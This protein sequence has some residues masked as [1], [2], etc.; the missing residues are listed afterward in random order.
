[1][2]IFL[3][4]IAVFF[5]N[6]PLHSYGSSDIDTLRTRWQPEYSTQRNAYLE[7]T[8]INLINNNQSKR[9]SSSIA[10]V[11]SMTISQS[12]IHSL[13]GDYR[14]EEVYLSPYSCNKAPISIH[15][16]EE[17]KKID[18]VFSED[19]LIDRIIPNELLNE[20]KSKSDSID[21]MIKEKEKL[22]EDQNKNIKSKDG[23]IEQK[24]ELIR[25]KDE[26][27]KEKDN[28]IKEIISK[29]LAKKVEDTKVK[30]RS[31]SESKDKDHEMF[32][33]K[34]MVKCYENADR[35]CARALSPKKS[36]LQIPN[37]NYIGCQYFKDPSLE[38]AENSKKAIIGDIVSDPTKKASLSDNS[39]LSFISDMIDLQLEKIQ[40]GSLIN[41][42]LSKTQLLVGIV[43]IIYLISLG[44]QISTG[45]S[46]GVLIGIIKIILV[47]TLTTPV[48]T[49]NY[50][51]NES[52]IN[53]NKLAI[54]NKTVI[55]EGLEL[56]RAFSIDLSNSV[57]SNGKE[58]TTKVDAKSVTPKSSKTK[59]DKVYKSV[60][61]TDDIAI[62][63]TDKI[64]CKMRN[65]LGFDFSSSNGIKIGLLIVCVALFVIG[66]FSGLGL[67]MGIGKA[68]LAVC[69]GILADFLVLIIFNKVMLTILAILAPFF[70]CFW[71]IEPLSKYF[72]RYISL[73]ISY[74][75]KPSLAIVFIT[76]MLRIIELKQY[77]S[78]QFE[79][80]EG[81]KY[82][83]KISTDWAF[84]PDKNKA[85]ECQQSFMYKLN[86]PEANKSYSYDDFI[87]DVF[88]LLFIYFVVAGLSAQLMKFTEL[89]DK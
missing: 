74:I 15:D 52:S 31:F 11:P 61:D 77:S 24:D 66:I 84:Y 27:I 86:S 68:P 2:K 50:A 34:I 4:F 18:L 13:W 70:L 75:L 47:I 55:S 44:M 37:Y 73:I 1:M 43:S 89:V 20:I 54:N 69:I 46:D 57:L 28:K 38:F 51:S 41:G 78:C 7:F 39:V 26:L 49:K 65:L 79:K 33:F 42:I 5:A 16:T 12:I 72:D 14:S 22:I 32:K 64:W 48:K 80:P 45:S 19:A 35:C 60:C 8:S 10:E 40:S 29:Y 58:K 82:A 6:M 30:S 3:F 59:S 53:F 17:N 71:L 63:I 56:A 87:K 25:Q 23:L 67:L 81:S 36:F 21:G 88:V 85:E 76:F 9:C 83:T 62:T